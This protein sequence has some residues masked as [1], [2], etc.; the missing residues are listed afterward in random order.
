M[1]LKKQIRKIIAPAIIIGL[2][3]VSYDTHSIEH[4]K[5]KPVPAQTSI[6]GAT[7]DLLMGEEMAE[8]LATIGSG[9]QVDEGDME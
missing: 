6:V 5:I 3:L 9:Q 8:F 2:A 4:A 7:T 1:P